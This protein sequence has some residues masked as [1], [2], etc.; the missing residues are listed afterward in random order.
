MNLDEIE[1][2]EKTPRRRHNHNNDH[3]HNHMYDNR[4]INNVPY[5]LIH[6]NNSN[7]NKSNR[8]N[9]DNYSLAL[10]SDTN[11]TNNIIDDIGDHIG[12]NLVGN[13]YY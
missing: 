12:V 8:I 6:S 5:E 13:K 11:V 7:Y 1:E 9:I 4:R 10:N 2:V 3:M